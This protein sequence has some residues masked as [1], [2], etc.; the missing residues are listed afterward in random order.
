MSRPPVLCAGSTEL[1]GRP[2]LELAEEL[3]RRVDNNAL[4]GYGLCVTFRQQPVLT[5]IYGLRDIDRGLPVNID[6]LF[7]QFSMTKAIVSVAFMTFCE[8]GRVTLDDDVATI[9]GAAWSPAGGLQV[10]E[11]D[12]LL[13][14][15]KDD[16]KAL[17]RLES[18]NTIFF[19]DVTTGFHIDIDPTGKGRCRW[20]DP[21]EWQAFKVCSMECQKQANNA[22]CCMTIRAHTGLFLD[23]QNGFVSAS[24]TDAVTWILSPQASTERAN[25]SCVGHISAGSVV[26][27]QHVETGLYLAVSRE[28]SVED[29]FLHVT[30]NAAIAAQFKVQKQSWQITARPAKNSIS[31]RHLL[32]H[33]SGLDYAGVGEVPISALDDLARKLKDRVEGRQLL[34]L[35]DWTAELAKLPLRREPGTKFEYGWSLDVLGRVVEVLGGAPLDEVLSKR[36]FQPLKMMSTYFATSHQDASARLSAL[37]RFRGLEKNT[38]N[39]ELKD[40]PLS[41]LWVPPR[42]P[43]PVLGGGGGVETYAGGLLSTIPDYLRF[44]YM[45]LGKGSLDGVRLLREETVEL[46]IRVNHLERMGLNNIWDGRGWGLLGGIELPNKSQR[47]D[48]CHQPGACGWGGWASTSFRVYPDRDV[49]FVFMTN[50]IDGINYEEL[51]RKKIGESLQ[52]RRWQ[53]L[54]RAM[55]GSTCGLCAAMHAFSIGKKG[56]RDK[57]AAIAVP[58]PKLAS[59]S[60][61]QPV[62][63]QSL[64]QNA[65]NLA[66]EGSLNHLEH[67]VANLESE[68]RLLTVRQLPKHDFDIQLQTLPPTHL[69]SPGTALWP[70]SAPPSALHTRP[71][72]RDGTIPRPIGA[73]GNVAAQLAELE[74]LTEQLRTV[75]QSGNRG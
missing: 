52:K 12:G 28:G 4:P 6:T 26:S 45:L 47:A 69:G 63:L 43:S 61:E 7:R 21:G 8:E 56:H 34:T 1:D 24:S 29:S 3:R 31:F 46:M 59:L 44:C 39:R 68:N 58:D 65:R 60:V 49:A 53:H 38:A 17:C 19:R 73:A 67:E 71:Q 9:L 22:S 64:L 5:D 62:M 70:G 48:P 35:K 20:D 41:S 75:T 13:S 74:S 25:G 57:R 11:H 66:D 23:V 33:S 27:L 16:D 40:D 10:V 42:G 32:T 37:Y 30:E 54:M 14:G 15:N 51:I 36:I 50:C 55:D 18:G 2:L 72:A